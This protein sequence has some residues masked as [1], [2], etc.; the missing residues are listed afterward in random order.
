MTAV[1]PGEKKLGLWTTTSLV[2][3]NMIGAG[4][5]LLPATLASF[6]SISLLGWIVSSIGAL[7]LAMVFSRLSKLLPNADG[8]PYA[9][10]KSS[11]GNFAAFLVAWGYWIS[12]WTS[13]A[14][15]AVSLV[16]ALS[17]FFPLLA[18]NS[19]AAILT[20]LGAIWL[21]TWINTRGI[22]ESGKLQLATTILKLVPLALVSVGGLFFI[23][24]KN[25]LPVNISGSSDF[26]AV[27]ASAA[28]TFFAF[29][30]MECATIPAGNVKNPARTIPRAT[31]IGTLITT[32]LYIMGTISL[33]GIIPARTLQKSGAPFADAAAII[34][35]ESARYW[36]GA[37][38]AIAAFGALNGWILIQAQISSSM[39]K[40][41]L[42]PAI[43]CKEN[44]NKSPG[45]GLAIGS[46][47]ISLCMLMNFAKGLVDQF[48][49][50]VLLT[51][52]TNLI[53]YLFSVA[54]YI[55]FIRRQK[56][57]GL[58]GWIKALT[59]A[60]PAFLFCVWAIVGSGKTVV[61][62]GSLLLIAGIPFYFWLIRGKKTPKAD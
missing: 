13:N 60:I 37:G 17:V 2:I 10:T 26:S 8:G 24:W 54:A 33:L 45:Q 40:D 3:G 22:R 11:F 27:T 51:I 29:L 62:D 46:I 57:T 36:V 47:L 25:F 53:P 28:L 61:L 35:G 6:G 41:K 34:W 18:A 14:A 48:Q 59:L 16:S 49:L 19:M 7:L 4:I 39:A 15:I 43:F 12:C 42:F 44:K 9:F 38:V 56:E 32:L 23:H 52:L 30:G 31:L 58:S 55:M 1:Q 50:L 20:G 21:L 5:F